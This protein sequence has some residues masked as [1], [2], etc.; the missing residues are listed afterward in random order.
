[1]I[2]TGLEGNKIAVTFDG[3]QVI[4]ESSEIPELS[5]A[6]AITIHKSQGSEFPAV[7]IPMATQHFVM[8]QRNLV[9]TALTRARKLAIF[10]GS[11]KALA[12][13]VKQVDCM[14]RQTR[15]AERLMAAAEVIPKQNT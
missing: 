10:V 14:G 8:L 2:A 6:Y 5:L 3:R 13:A 1:M 9:Y 7:I 15:L 4:Y 12:I 11:R